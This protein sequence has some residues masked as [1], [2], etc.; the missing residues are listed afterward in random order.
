[1]SYSLSEA[2]FLMDADKVSTGKI[3]ELEI[4]RLNF[5]LLVKKMLLLKHKSVFL[6]LIK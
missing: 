6:F 5:N 3:L 2:V 4:I 1:M